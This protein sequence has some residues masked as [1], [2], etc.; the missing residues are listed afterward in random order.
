MIRASVEEQSC[1]YNNCLMFSVT[2]MKS[3][4]EKLLLIFVLCII[5]SSYILNVKAENKV[6]VNSIKIDVSNEDVLESWDAGISNN[7]INTTP[8]IK[9]DC[10]S[11]LEM[12]I[13][14]YQDD[15]LVSQMTKQSEKPFK[16]LE[17]ANFCASVEYIDEDDGC[18]AA[19]GEQNASDCDISSMFN[20]MNPGNYKT[21][22]EMKENDTEFATVTLEVTVEAE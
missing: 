19:P 8:K 12:D 15:Q 3:P 20:S 6:T 4:I 10:P 22:C 9:K 1:F 7:L 17:N 18:S 5:S 11:I 2:I 13:K 21:V 16:D 14:I